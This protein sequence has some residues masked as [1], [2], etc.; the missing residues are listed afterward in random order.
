M[1]IV[2]LL[3]KYEAGG[4]DREEL[5]GYPPPFPATVWIVNLREKKN[6]RKNS[7][8]TQHHL[9]PPLKFFQMNYEVDVSIMNEIKTCIS[10]FLN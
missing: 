9:P 2:Q 5:K 7:V 3:C 8:S 6:I 10:I 1:L 4:S